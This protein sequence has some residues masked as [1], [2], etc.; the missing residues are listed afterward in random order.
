MHYDECLTYIWQ[1]FQQRISEDF[2]INIFWAFLLLS[3]SC[4]WEQSIMFQSF[5]HNRFSELCDRRNAIW[6]FHE[7]KNKCFQMT[8][9]CLQKRE[10][11]KAVEIH[12]LQHESQRVKKGKRISSRVHSCIYPA[13]MRNPSVQSGHKY[14]L[15]E[16]TESSL[17]TLCFP[18]V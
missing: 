13:A 10:K 8:M 14:S 7:S 12:L 16:P 11:K 3:D 15:Y 18:T 5:Q 2:Q 17:G 1:N 4:K 9:S 6:G